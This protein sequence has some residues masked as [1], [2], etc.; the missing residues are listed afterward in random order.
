M[1]R[2]HPVG[3]VLPKRYRYTCSRVSTTRT[4]LRILRLG[5]K[6]L[7]LVLASSALRRLGSHKI[8]KIQSDKAIFALTTIFQPINK[9]FG[10]KP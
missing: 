5:S 10:P 9:K 4:L 3:S 1:L 7:A 6:K 8:R 2:E